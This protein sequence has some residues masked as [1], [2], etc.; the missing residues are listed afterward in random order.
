[1][2]IDSNETSISCQQCRRSLTARS[3]SADEQQFNI[4]V[5]YSEDNILEDN[6]I[7][8]IAEIQKNHSSY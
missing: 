3:P 8:P 6:K 5:D 7:L 4:Q 1:M 2:I